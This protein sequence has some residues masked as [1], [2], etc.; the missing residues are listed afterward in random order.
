M[1]AR[2]GGAA[3]WSYTAERPSS[4]LWCPSTWYGSPASPGICSNKPLL[5]FYTGAM[6]GQ[7]ETELVTITHPSA[8]IQTPEISWVLKKERT[9]Q[10]WW[11][12]KTIQSLPKR[13]CGFQT[14]PRIWTQ[15]KGH[16]LSP[17]RTCFY[18]PSPNRTITAY[19]KS[20]YSPVGMVTQA[21]FSKPLAETACL[22]VVI[23]YNLCVGWFAKIRKKYIPELEH[24]WLL[25]H[26]C[27][28]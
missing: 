13:P 15:G 24:L 9:G 28:F 12:P 25:Y 11:L 18:L 5:P 10:H 2:A 22:R 23:S 16:I 6:L 19:A 17:Q 14:A 4:A 3:S 8:K 1:R 27:I 26:Y 20:C 21:A 7:L